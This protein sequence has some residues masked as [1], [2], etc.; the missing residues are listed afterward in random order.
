[1][2]EFFDEYKEQYCNECE[3]KS[4]CQ[5]ACPYV[6]REILGLGESQTL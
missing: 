3:E 5:I 4:E 2:E 1:M 6:F